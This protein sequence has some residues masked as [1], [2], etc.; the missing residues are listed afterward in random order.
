MGII[1]GGAID[2]GAKKENVLCLRIMSKL[3]VFKDLL[4][5]S[6]VLL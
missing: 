2:A 3:Q 1:P 6:D 5:L 4:K